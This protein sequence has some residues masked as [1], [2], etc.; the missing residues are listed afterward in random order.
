MTNVILL[1]VM[2]TCNVLSYLLATTHTRGSADFAILFKLFGFMT[3]V[4]L[5]LNLIEGC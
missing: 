2:I 1:S 5:F 3:C 4:K